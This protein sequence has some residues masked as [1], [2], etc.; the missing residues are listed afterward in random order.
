M[1]DNI[2]TCVTKMMPLSSVKYEKLPLL[3][4][5]DITISAADKQN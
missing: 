1:K 2:L 4:I 5:Y 3:Q